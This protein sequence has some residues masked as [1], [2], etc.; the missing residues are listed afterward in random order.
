MQVENLVTV[1]FTE[2]ELKE[3]LLCSLE[4][5][6]NDCIPGTPEYNRKERL[7]NHIRSETCSMEW[8]NG[9]FCLSADGIAT[10]EPF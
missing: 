9:K 1:S 5:K 10:V 2:E 6:M 7:I 8:V 4:C 3:S